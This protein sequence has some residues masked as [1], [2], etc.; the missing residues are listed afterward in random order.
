MI[1]WKAKEG[2]LV[3]NTRPQSNTPITC[4]EERCLSPMDSPGAAHRRGVV[5]PHVDK[6]EG[7]PAISVRTTPNLWHPNP[8]IVSAL[9]V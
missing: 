4:R 5:A 8:T 9:V 2:W 1:V 6:T 7:R 3:S